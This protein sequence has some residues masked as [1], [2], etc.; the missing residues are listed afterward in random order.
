MAKV[1]AWLPPS[2]FLEEKGAAESRSPSGDGPLQRPRHAPASII[3]PAGKQRH[4]AAQLDSPGNDRSVNRPPRRQQAADPPAP[5]NVEICCKDKTG[6]ARPFGLERLPGGLFRQREV[7]QVSRLH[8]RPG[9]AALTGLHL[10]PC[11]CFTVSDSPGEKKKS[12]C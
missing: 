1:D 7:W 10:V 5:Q 12:L 2:H 3:S 9:V 4:L 6:P 11:Q 8:V